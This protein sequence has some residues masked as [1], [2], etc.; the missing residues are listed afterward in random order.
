MER[1]IFLTHPISCKRV[2][3][4]LILIHFNPKNIKTVNPIVRFEIHV[5]DLERAQ[6]FYENVLDIKLIEPKIQLNLMKI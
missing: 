6:K 5:D 1:L 4:N 3:G 2:E